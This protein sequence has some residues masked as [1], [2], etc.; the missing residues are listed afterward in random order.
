M[1]R[2]EWSR[3]IWMALAA[4]ATAVVVYVIVRPPAHVA[5]EPRDLSAPA[6]VAQL[7][8]SGL[9]AIT[10][11]S[12]LDHKLA[13]RSVETETVTS[14]LLTVTAS[15]A[16]H[17]VAGTANPKDRWQFQNADISNAY[18]DWRRAQNDV[19]FS[20]KQLDKT[21]ELA[22]AQV[23]RFTAVYERLKKLVATGTETPKDLAAAKADLVQAE[24]Q[25]KKDVFDAESARNLAL[26]NRA[27]AER[28]LQQAG[29]DPLDLDTREEEVAI[30]V[31]QVPEAKMAVV[32]EGEGCTARFYGIVDRTFPGRVARIAPTLSSERRTLRVLFELPD[33]ANR[34]KPGM[35]ADVGLGTDPRQ[36]L[37]IP[38]DA[39]IHAGRAEFVFARS[40]PGPWQVREVQLGEALGDTIEVHSGLTAGEQVIGAGAILLKPFL[41]RALDESADAHP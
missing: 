12:A 39:V 29:I 24:L 14:P 20:A 37:L 3:N 22:A 28:T 38:T 7:V 40:A 35:F 11:G 5:P 10:A 27:A 1:T 32:H 31:A 8:G 18:A 36:A 25:T 19:E 21:R 30:V 16:A 6:D 41:I 9:V 2:T 4:I 13:V 34:L 15:V 33:P 17:F 26:R 23:S